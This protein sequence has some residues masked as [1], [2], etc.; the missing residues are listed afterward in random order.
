MRC[1]AE[2][3]NGNL[4]LSVLESTLNLDDNPESSEALYLLRPL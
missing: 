3:Q 1:T 4:G 2:G